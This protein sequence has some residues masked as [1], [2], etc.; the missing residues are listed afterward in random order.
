MCPTVMGSPSYCVLCI[1]YKTLITI[2]QLLSE[3]ENCCGSSAVS[4]CCDK[5][6]AE[7]NHNLVVHIFHPIILKY[8]LIFREQ[9]GISVE[10][11]KTRFNCTTASRENL[12]LLILYLCTVNL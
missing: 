5:L 4:C 3:L 1:C 12:V 10:L 7:A 8:I 2:S 6:V 9:K 11:K